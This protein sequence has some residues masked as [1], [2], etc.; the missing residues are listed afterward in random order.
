MLPFLHIGKTVIIFHIPTSFY[1][2]FFHSVKS[3]PGGPKICHMLQ[4]KNE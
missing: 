1:T 4:Y 3:I 2:L